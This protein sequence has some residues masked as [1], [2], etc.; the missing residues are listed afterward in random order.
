MLTRRSALK[1]GFFGSGLVFVGGGLALNARAS[2]LQKPARPLLVL[3]EQEFSIVA[4]MADRIVPGNGAFLP[5][6]K[7]EVAHR[8][9]AL[10]ARLQP[11][12][13][14]DLSRLLHLFESGVANFL[15]DG[16][17]QTF[18]QMSAEDQDAALRDWQRS[19]LSPR[20]AIYKALRGVIAA[21]Y[22]GVQEL[23]AAVGYPG[24]PSSADQ[25]LHQVEPATRL[26][27]GS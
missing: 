21:S 1:L 3:T 4:A 17:G 11:G 5:P 7:L 13:A 10:F 19:R 23:D 6:E 20:R 14:K 15:F 24:P 9:D 8:V 22:F 12:L 2:K 26:G 27:S 18:T 16:R 25:P